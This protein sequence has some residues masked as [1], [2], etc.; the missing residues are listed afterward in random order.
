M[1]FDPNNY[2]VEKLS[3]QA[4]A[5]QVLDTDFVPIIRYDSVEND[6]SNFTVAAG[7]FNK[8]L[9]SGYLVGFS[10][11]VVQNGSTISSISVTRGSARSDDDVVSIIT[12]STLTNSNGIWGDMSKPTGTDIL[13][14]FVVAT[15]SQTTTN[16]FLA[17]HGSYPSYTL[18]R[19]RVVGQGLYS[20]NGTTESIHDVVG[21]DNEIISIQSEDIIS[22]S[23]LTNGKIILVLE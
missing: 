1:S 20:N 18:I 15:D 17:R 9:P 8:I 23:A 19:T 7:Q 5:S 10:P 11:S 13:V 6:Y 12:T 22:G 14:D 16:V 21:F 2:D 4:S 3:E